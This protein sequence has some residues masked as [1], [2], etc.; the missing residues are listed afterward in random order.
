MPLDRPGLHE[1]L[2]QVGARRD[3]LGIDRRGHVEV[4]ER[5]RH[6]VELAVRVPERPQVHRAIEQRHERDGDDGRS[7][8]QA[9]RE[10][11]LQRDSR[12]PRRPH[13]SEP[14]RDV[15]M[16][17]QYD[18]GVGE[19]GGPLVDAREEARM[20][21][22]ARCSRSKSTMAACCSSSRSWSM[23]SMAMSCGSPTSASAMPSRM[24][25]LGVQFADAGVACVSQ[26]DTLEQRASARTGRRPPRNSRRSAMC[27]AAVSASSRSFT[28]ATRPS[29]TDLRTRRASPVTSSPEDE[30]GAGA[31]SHAS[32]EREQQ[33]RTSRTCRAEQGRHSALG[34]DERSGR[35][36]QSPCECAVRVRARERRVCPAS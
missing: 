9:V 28:P 34:G 18:G 7:D 17:G 23:S 21:R 12:E 8:E 20:R 36:H 4:H 22:R 26:A 3:R 16:R 1:R 11:P 32:C 19:R 27:S 25:A 30:G 10:E 6:L 24:H 13:R 15:A 2:G 5:D 33:R 14:P 35:V 29:P 31:R